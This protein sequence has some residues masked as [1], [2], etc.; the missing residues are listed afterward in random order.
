MRGERQAP[1][2]SLGARAGAVCKVT[3]IGLRLLMRWWWQGRVEVSAPGVLALLGFY[4]AWVVEVW[5]RP[6]L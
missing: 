4:A 3:G 6:Y 1:D 2:F 5:R